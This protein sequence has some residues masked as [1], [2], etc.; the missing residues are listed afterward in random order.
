MDDK[1]FE[2]A[3]ERV[4]TTHLEG[5]FISKLEHI[6]T[7]KFDEWSAQHRAAQDQILVAI[8]GLQSQ[9]VFLGRRKSERHV[10]A[11]SSHATLVQFQTSVDPPKRL[12][13]HSRHSHGDSPHQV[14]TPVGHHKEPV[15]SLHDLETN[16][17]K[18]I[19]NITVKKVASRTS[20]K[21]WSDGAA[22]SAGN[23][24][25]L[26]Q[27]SP[28][29]AIVPVPPVKIIPADPM[30]E[31]RC[32]P[33][34]LP[35]APSS[36]GDDL[37]E[38][39]KPMRKKILLMKKS[40]DTL[41]VDQPSS[42]RRIRSEGSASPVTMDGMNRDSQ[43]ALIYDGSCSRDDDD[44]KGT[45]VEWDI[46]SRRLLRNPCL[47]QLLVALPALI[48]TSCF[49]SLKI[50]GFAQRVNYTF[51]IVATMLYG[52]VGT[53]GV[54]LLV[55]SLRSPNFNTA[56]YRLHVFVADWR[57]YWNDVSRLE[58][59]RYFLAWVVM[60][61]FYTCTQLL[62]AWMLEQGVSEVVGADGD[63]SRILLHVLEATSL[64]GFAFTSGI[65]LT[66][67][68][69]QSHLLLGLDKSL[70]CWCNAISLE[71]DFGI[72]TT[73]WNCMQ[74]LLKCVGRELETS[75]VT[76]QV[77]GA[78]G[79]IFFLAS[80]VAF[81]FRT[82]FESLPMLVE[83]MSSLPLLFLFA[84]NLRIFANAAALTEKCRRIP[85]FV[86]QIP[87][88]DY[89]DMERQYLVRFISDSSPGFFVRDIRLTQEMFLKQFLLVGG[90]LSGL[91]GVLSRVL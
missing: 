68:S 7:I 75:F 2:R 63:I 86:N 79:F 29:S 70:D 65:V 72:G 80:A 14:Q 10:P 56:M 74:A 26:S 39:V 62:D 57:V 22:G 4:L 19:A 66:V 16:I 71:P 73:S 45:T 33:A 32:E 91:V 30:L 48:N 40:T 35:H 89:L 82:N 58:S 21:S 47:I 76:V 85:A 15:Q 52:L 31:D 9:N 69:A 20:R 43:Q 12:S 53:L 17:L 25:S 54:H 67:A 46:A 27:M 83:A 6:L 23:S 34:M 51:T 3:L 90:L 84:T 87:S 41:Q 28:S 60:V 36:E 78:V 49:A 88:Q 37:K 8:Q 59:C 24:R 50:L 42:P 18:D 55:K 5:H 81:V 1:Y 11:E 77:L 61:C 44:E 64:L 13:R 38:S